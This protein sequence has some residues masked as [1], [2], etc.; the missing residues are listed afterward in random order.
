[1]RLK[2]SPF[3]PEEHQA[4]PDACQ[5]HGVIWQSFLKILEKKIA[6]AVR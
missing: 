5:H 1:M 4:A 2:P 3:L 6:G